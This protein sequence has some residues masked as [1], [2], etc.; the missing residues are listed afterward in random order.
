MS[1]RTAER[2]ADLVKWRDH[3]ATDAMSIENHIK[4]L[5]KFNDNLLETLADFLEDITDLEG[6]P[7]ES[8]GR[9][10]WTAGGMRLRGDLT[11]FG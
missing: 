4:F 11:R 9:R 6:K 10:I 3:H 2:L 5:E 8:L 7:R 1:Q